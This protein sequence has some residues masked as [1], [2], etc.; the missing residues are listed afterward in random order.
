M[1]LSEW[2]TIYIKHKDI[3]EKKLVS[4]DES[5]EKIFFKYTY[6]NVTGV[7]MD[8][9]ELPSTEGET[10]VATLN[11]KDNVQFLIDNW[12]EFEK[13]PSLTLIFVH[14]KTNEKWLIRPHIHKHIQ[15]GKVELGIWSLAQSVPFS[16]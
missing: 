13:I 14:I 10:V 1:N 16:A 5:K 2:L 12:T 3:M 15:E 6:K 4:I 7:P 11:T 8:K 9:L